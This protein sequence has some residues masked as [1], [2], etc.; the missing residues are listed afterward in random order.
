[1][2]SV[3]SW[4]ASREKHL[5]MISPTIVLILL[6]AFSTF[7]MQTA[8]YSVTSPKVVTTIHVGTSPSYIGYNPSNKGIYVVSCSR[9]DG[10]CNGSVFV[11]NSSTNLVVAKV[12]IGENP[13]GIIYDPARKAMYVA[14]TGPGC[15]PPID[16]VSVISGTKLVN[17]IGFGNC[18][19][20]FA[21]NPSNKDLYVMNPGSQTGNS[22]IYVL[23]S[24]TNKLVATISVPSPTVYPPMYDPSNHEVYFATSQGGSIYA[25]KGITI[26]ANISMQAKV[27]TY[28]PSNKLVYASGGPNVLVIDGTTNKVVKSLPGGGYGILYDPANRNVYYESAGISVV[29][30]ATNTVTKTLNTGG[31]IFNPFTPSLTYNSFN[32]DLYVMGT[33]HLPGNGGH[34]SN[35]TVLV[36]SSQNKLVA[37]LTL[38]QTFTSFFDSILYDP[39]NHNV[40]VTDQY[41]GTLWVISS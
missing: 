20:L 15:A 39:A 19:N 10:A 41:T 9:R 30:P 8:S 36:F 28:D 26:V 34:N 24:L 29:N 32:G 22:Q 25:L 35:T 27:F 14:D 33:M 3:S 6:F 21:Y 37:N 2:G 31:L 5:R 11:I 4:I 1:M 16:N 38:T 18:L 7:A 23:N 40:Y 12:K 17:T 13:S